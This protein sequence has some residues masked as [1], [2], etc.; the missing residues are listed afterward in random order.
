MRHGTTLTL[1]APPQRIPLTIPACGGLLDCPYDKFKT[2][3]T[4]HLRQD[5]LV[6]K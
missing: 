3:I 2:F 1:N 6:K 4:A 5:C